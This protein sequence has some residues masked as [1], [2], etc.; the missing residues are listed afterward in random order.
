MI[1]SKRGANNK[2]DC[3]WDARLKP[4]FQQSD[5]QKSD[6]QNLSQIVRKRKFK[7][8]IERNLWLK[9]KRPVPKLS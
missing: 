7:G 6:L 4:P 1:C 8:E 9:M 2:I 5:V 3:L